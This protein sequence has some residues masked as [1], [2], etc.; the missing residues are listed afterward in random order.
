MLELE[1]QNLRRNRLKSQT[2]TQVTLDDDFIVPDTMSDMAEVILDSGIIQLEPVKVQRERITVRGKLDFHVLYRKEEGGLQALG[3]SI[4]FEEAINVPDLDEKDYVSVSWQLEDLNTEMIHSRK[5]GIKAIVTLEAKA[6]SLYDTEAAVDVRGEDDEIHLQVRRERIP[7]AAIAL[8]RKDTYRLKQDITLPG[9]KP[10]IERMLWTE[11]KLAGCQAKPLDGQ[12]HLE[13]TLMIFALYEGGESGMVQ[14]VEE[15]IPFSG[16]VEMQGAAAD[17]IPIIGLK[18]IHR[19]LEERPDYDGEMRELSVDA[20]IELD[21]RL[22]E[23]QELELLQ[24]LY[25]TNREIVLDTGEAVFDQI[26]TRNFGKCRVA[27]K[28][29]METDPR[30][31]QICHSSGSVKLDGVEVRENELA[32]DGVL[33]VKLLYLTDEDARPVQAATRLVPFH[34]EAETPGIT[35]DSI[36][37]LEPGLEQLTA[38]MAG[39]GQAE[40]R[41]VITLDLFVLQPET[42]QIIL[43]AQVHPVDTEKM[44]AMPGIVGYLVQPG[45]SLWDVAKRFHTTEKSILEA[46]ELPGDAIKAGD[47]LILVKE[48]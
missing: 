13:G 26:L 34:Y 45:D 41:G 31:L 43:Q 30:V 42:R 37:Y 22:Y 9:S 39:G 2:G 20:V 3:G 14:W 12:I 47:C 6:E 32:V 16:E 19:D 44:K 5:L 8:R 18:L 1:K 27:E 48:I 17:M 15:S 29:E 4:P 28:V 25:A 35:E 36:W 38:V 33:E 10:V 21:V 11:M 46:N 23:E 24:D 40:L 7:A